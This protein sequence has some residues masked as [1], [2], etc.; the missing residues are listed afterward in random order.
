MDYLKLYLKLNSK[1]IFITCFVQGVGIYA[2]NAP[3]V[4]SYISSHAPLDILVVGDA[5]E[6]ERIL[7]GREAKKAFPDVKVWNLLGFF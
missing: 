1:G 3:D 7:D 2:T 5:A 4:V 6:L